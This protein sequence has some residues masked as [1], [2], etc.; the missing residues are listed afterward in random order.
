MNNQDKNTVDG[1]GDE[2]TTFDYA[3]TETDKALDAQFLA[4][5]APIELI[6]EMTMHRKSALF[7]I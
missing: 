1:F 3:L 7:G 5:S 6:Q 4:Y 2:W